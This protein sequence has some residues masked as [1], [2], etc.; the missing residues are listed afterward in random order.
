MSAAVRP[1]A[2]DPLARWERIVDPFLVIAAIVPLIG[3]VTDVSPTL[4]TWSVELVCWLVFAVDLAVHLRLR[5]GYL[6]TTAGKIDLFIVVATF[7]WSV[8]IGDE[9]VRLLALFR[10]AR[11]ARIVVILRRSALVRTLVERLGRPTVVLVATL[12]ICS[13][14]IYR[15]EPASAGFRDYGDALWFGIVTVTTV[16]YGELSAT[17]TES[18]IAAV[19]M[20]IVG[21]MF[22]GSVLATA[23]AAL[24]SRHA[25]VD[26]YSHDDEEPHDARPSPLAEEVR[27]L[28]SELREL[29]ALVERLGPGSSDPSSGRGTS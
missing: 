17:T 4:G 19:V 7:P 13:F 2:A 10:L 16:G 26:D 12:L 18:R 9:Q 6:R 23:T 28:R 21:I 11:V 27:A 5:P 22:L 3:N 20:I 1:T 25:R 24:R 29:H 14:V 15:N 8:A